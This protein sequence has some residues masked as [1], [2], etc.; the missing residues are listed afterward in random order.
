MDRGNLG[1]IAATSHTANVGALQISNGAIINGSAWATVGGTTYVLVHTSAGVGCPGPSGDLVAV[2]LEPA[3][4]Q[5]MSVAWCA[6]NQGRGSPIITSSD[7]T[8]DGLVWSFGAEGSNGLHAW[9]LATGAVVFAGGGSANAVTGGHRFATV[10]AAKGRV[11]LAA[12]GGLHAF[13]GP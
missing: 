7:G 4:P 13:K 10:L 12:D 11:V 3:A 5:K 6:N 8:K 1:G 9:D 2:K